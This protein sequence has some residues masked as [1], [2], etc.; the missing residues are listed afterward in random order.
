MLGLGL[1][2]RKAAAGAMLTV[3]EAP[4]MDVAM[5]LGARVNG[6]GMPT[7]PLRA[8]LDV[9]AALFHHQRARRVLITGDD[10]RAVS[11][12]ITPM[13]RAL[14]EAGVPRASLLIDGAGVRTFESFRNAREVFG[15]ERLLVVTNPFHLPRSL[16]LA[17]GVGLDAVGVLAPEAPP[18]GIRQRFKRELREQ[19]ARA[20]AVI[21]VA[22]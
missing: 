19:V 5:V 8:R 15:L 22:R 3:A 6:D 20:R 4:A 10:G 16:F 17:R 7:R 1:Y 9:A 13:V 14:L 11:D 12:E 21:D 18:P 2:M